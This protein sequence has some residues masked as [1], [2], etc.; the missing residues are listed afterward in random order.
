MPTRSW[1]VLMSLAGPASTLFGVWLLTSPEYA[2]D[3]RLRIQKLRL[4]LRIVGT[5]T[6]GWLS[7]DWLGISSSFPFW[8][9]YQVFF[10]ATVALQY[11]YLRT[12]A[13][14]SRNPFLIR[15]TPVAMFTLIAFAALSSLPRLTGTIPPYNFVLF[16][17]S[18]V[19]GYNS[20]LLFR[21]AMVLHRAV[22]AARRKF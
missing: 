16:I 7:A 13:I 4:P 2:G 17:G 12:V 8:I 15:H 6:F 10:I 3:G 20:V 9:A 14:R 18:L 22:V 5:A 19:G 11:S 1:V 21:Y